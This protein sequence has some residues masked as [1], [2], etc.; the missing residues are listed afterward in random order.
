MYIVGARSSSKGLPYGQTQFIVNLK[1]MVSQTFVGPDQPAEQTQN[2]EIRSF[3]L[4]I[5]ATKV[6]D[7]YKTA[8]NSSTKLA[9]Q[10]LL[11]DSALP[12]LKP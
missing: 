6:G 5:S 8:I 7:K 2:V 12:L 3:N 11:P 10:Q 1:V 4:S 9:D